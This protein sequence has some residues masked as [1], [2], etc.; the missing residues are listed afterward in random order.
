MTESHPTAPIPGQPDEVGT[1]TATVPLPPPP[2][3]P[4]TPP[5]PAAAAPRRRPG[6]AVVV[7]TSLLAGALG[8]GLGAGAVIATDDDSPTGNGSSA[9]AADV[10]TATLPDGSVAKV[11]AKVLPSVVSIQFTGTAGSGTGSGVV[12]DDSGLIVTNNHVVE[13]AAN[14]GSLTV[15][16]QDGTTTSAEI[17]GRDPSADLAVIRVDGVD[18]LVPAKL[19]NSDDLQVGESVI[20][21]GSPLGLNGTVTTGIVSALNRPVL[22]DPNSS[23]DSV[24]NAIQTDAAINPGNSGGA[25]VNLDGELV[26]INSA[27]ATLGASTG[28]QSGS[29]GLG[30]AIPVNEAKWISNQ[31]ISDGTAEHARLGVTVEPSTGDVLGAQVGTVESG[32]AADKAGLAEGDVITEFGDQSIDSPDALVA[33]VRSIEPGAQVSITYV[34]DGQTHTVDAEMGTAPTS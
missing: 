8:A 27:I 6:M 31:L 1:T 22:P 4:W 30:F 15:S 13:E 9:S 12:I 11:A 5:A 16:F 23:D 25:L 14:G 29:I 32:S 2:Q 17:V 3:N 34:R 24:L 33:A 10:S 26:G 7:A 18:N 21:I 20:A 19:G 28:G